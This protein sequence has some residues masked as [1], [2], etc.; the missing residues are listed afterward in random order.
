MTIKNGGDKMCKVPEY[1]ITFKEPQIMN[2]IE[3]L[4]YH[5]KRT[6]DYKYQYDRVIILENKKHI[7]GSKAVFIN[8]ANEE[9]IIASNSL[10]GINAVIEKDGISVIE[11]MFIHKMGNEDEIREIDKVSLEQLMETLNEIRECILEEQED[12]W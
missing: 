4:Y 9:A 3:V 7:Y 12:E 11:S 6:N 5:P 1:E 8:S 2:I 10:N